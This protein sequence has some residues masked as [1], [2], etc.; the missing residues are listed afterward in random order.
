VRST[1]TTGLN[2]CNAISPTLFQ[3]EDVN[4]DG[5]DDIITVCYSTGA[6]NELSVVKLYVNVGYNEAPWEISVKD[7]FS[8]MVLTAE[9]GSIVCI[10]VGD[11]FQ[12]S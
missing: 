12:R 10:S 6:S 5:L 8:G 1:S 3:V 2:V 7:I 11:I 9:K 4:G